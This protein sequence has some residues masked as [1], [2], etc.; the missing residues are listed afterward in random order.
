SM[1]AATVA[2][3]LAR[4]TYRDLPL[5]MLVDTQ[6][7]AVTANF[8]VF[9]L[10]V[11]SGGE[12]ENSPW[13]EEQKEWQS[14][15]ARRGLERPIPKSEIIPLPSGGVFAEAVLGRFNSA[16]KLDLSRF[17]NWQDSPIPITAPDIAAV[18]AGSRAQPEDITPGQLSQPVLNIQAPTA[19]PEPTGVGAIIAAIQ[20][21]NM[22]RDM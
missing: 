3:L 14:W 20:Q 10:N 4:F 18:Q 19:L 22:F 5:G 9:K 12:P 1:D 16:E 11:T 13:G 6:P 21:G 17:W 2:A 7:F 8:L 15:L